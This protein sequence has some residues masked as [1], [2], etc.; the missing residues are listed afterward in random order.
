MTT[1]STSMI[2]VGVDGS[3]QA[4]AALSFA[5]TEAGRCGDTVHVVTS[6]D[7]SPYAVGLPLVPV[8]P[9][10]PDAGELERAAQQVQDDALAAAGAVEVPVVRHVVEGEAGAVLVDA[11]RDARLLVVGTRGLGGLRAAVLG[12]VSRYCA[13]HAACPVV[14]VPGP[15]APAREDTPEHRQ[16]PADAGR[17]VLTP[18]Y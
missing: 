5:L 10:P 9:L 6:W 18:L 17:S 15:H 8:P 12:S 4:A 16:R 7:L 14:V 3:P 1:Q 13:R 2:V 11:A